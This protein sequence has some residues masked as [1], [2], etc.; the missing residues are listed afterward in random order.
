M[1]MFRT[2][3]MAILMA[4]TILNQ[5]EEVDLVFFIF[6]LFFGELSPPHTCVATIYQ[7]LLIIT[8]GV[9]YLESDMV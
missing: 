8:R 7:I 2:I 3:K 6:Y 4:K 9:R 5:V 1:M